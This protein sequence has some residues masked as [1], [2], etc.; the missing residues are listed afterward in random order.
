MLL[1]AFLYSGC[2]CSQTQ[3]KSD[4]KV[5]DLL[6]EN[7]F[8]KGMEGPAVDAEGNLYAVNYSRQ[9]TIGVV[10]TN[11]EVSLFVALPEGSVGNGIRFDKKGSMYVADYTGHNVLIIQPSTKKVNVFAHNPDMNQ[12]NDLAIC[13]VTENLY[14]SDPNWKDST[15]M[16]WLIDRYGK[17]FLLEEKMG[18]TNGIEV[19][20]DG[21]LLY[22]NE[23]IQRYVWVYDIHSDGKVS[24]KRVFYK[25]N[26]FGMDGMRCDPA[27]NLY[28]TRHGK[29]TVVKLS[30][31]GTL[32][33]EYRLKGR[34]PTNIT[35]SN[36]YKKAFVT[37][38]D[39][40][41]FEVIEFL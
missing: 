30:P 10:N 25:F 9:G 5:K 22:V 4:Y 32:T 38:A 16:L 15:G 13:P 19:S 28:I 34:L 36:D 24:G 3:E 29:G 33:A 37:L 1:T 39:R 41:C 11:G 2:L 6:P 14:A 31:S 18:T 26:D 35:F 7:S 17:T 23:S 12:P 20:P 27:G 21:K 8:T 40:G